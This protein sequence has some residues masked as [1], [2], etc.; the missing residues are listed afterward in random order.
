VPDD[1]LLLYQEEKRGIC[2]SLS[3]LGTPRPI[4]RLRD[5]VEVLDLT[6]REKA[7]GFSGKKLE[8]ES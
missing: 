2:R 7:A 4:A 3:L 5:K 8:E 1:S 6:K